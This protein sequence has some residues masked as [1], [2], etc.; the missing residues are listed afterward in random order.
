MIMRRFNSSISVSCLPRASF[1]ARHRVFST[2]S[3][4]EVPPPK[5]G[6]LGWGSVAMLAVV[7]TGVVRLFCFVFFFVFFFFFFF[8]FFCFEK[9]VSYYNWLR[10][11]R[12]QKLKVKSMGRPAIGGP[13]SLVD[14]KGR[15]VTDN[16]FRGKY[17]LVYFGFT[18]CPEICPAE[19]TKMGNVMEELK[20]K[21][22][23]DAVVPVMITVDPRRD[24]VEQVARYVQ[25]FHPRLIGLTGTPQQVQE[26]SKLYRVY[27]STGYSE[28]EL[29]KIDDY[30]VDHTI[31]FYLMGP[32]GL[33]RN[34]F[35]QQMTSE[36]ISKGVL[37]AIDE[38]LELLKGPSLWSMILGK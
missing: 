32:D 23:D 28:E 17:M 14:H 12:I 33:I 37:D 15:P 7:G 22:F 30:Q 10:D 21:G 31:F 1:A 34:Y 11:R 13:F 2:S 27:A 6:P 4:Q 20:V 8:F 38:D 35:G 29:E 16:D 19:L 3:E 36:Q 18:F 25:E 24:T 9:K 26:V 5:R